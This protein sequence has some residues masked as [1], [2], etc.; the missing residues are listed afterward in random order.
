MELSAVDAFRNKLY[1]SDL[2]L[3]NFDNCLCSYVDTTHDFPNQETTNL[4]VNVEGTELKIKVSIVESDLFATIDVTPMKAS[5]A[6]SSVFLGIRI[7]PLFFVDQTK[8]RN[9]FLKP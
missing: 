7:N 4:F 3:P 6:E 9:K 8:S 2:H 1:D 5:T